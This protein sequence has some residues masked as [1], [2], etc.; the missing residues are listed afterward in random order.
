MSH[1]SVWYSRPRSYGKGAR[2][3]RVCTHKAGLI[4]KYGLNLCLPVNWRSISP[5]T[6]PPSPPQLY[7]SIY[8]LANELVERKHAAYCAER[9]GSDS[10]AQDMDIWPLERKTRAWKNGR[11]LGYNITRNAESLIPILPSQHVLSFTVGIVN[12]ADRRIT[13]IDTA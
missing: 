10:L 1:E 12:I 4:R 5:I 13:L 3:C 8:P 9:N 2:Q 6:I 11:G 7:Q